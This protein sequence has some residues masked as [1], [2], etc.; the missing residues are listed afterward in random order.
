[1]KRN[2]HRRLKL[3]DLVLSGKRE[4]SSSEIKV[5]QLKSEGKSFLKIGKELGFSGT[6]ARFLYLRFNEIVGYISK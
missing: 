2:R 4:V 5:A 3:R 1:M 6:R